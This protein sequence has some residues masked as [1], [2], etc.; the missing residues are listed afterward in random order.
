MLMFYQ[1]KHPRIIYF[2]G[3]R[4]SIITS[5]NFNTLKSLGQKSLNVESELQLIFLRQYLNFKNSNNTIIIS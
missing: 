4:F 5:E 2:R 1:L 3:T